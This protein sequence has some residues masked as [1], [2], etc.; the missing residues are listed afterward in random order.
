L[1]RERDFLGKG[2]SR[3]LLRRGIFGVCNRLSRENSPME[4]PQP[5]FSGVMFR[6]HV[7][8]IFSGENVCR[9]LLEGYAQG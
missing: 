8:D 1:Y 5:G 4:C 2:I 7:C 6:G 9:G 3:K